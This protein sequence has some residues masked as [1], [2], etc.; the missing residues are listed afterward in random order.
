MPAVVTSA[1]N[2]S[3]K[4]LYKMARMRQPSGVTAVAALVI[5]VGLTGC[6]SGSHDQSAL[7]RKRM[8]ESRASLSRFA[9]AFQHNFVSLYVSIDGTG[10]FVDCYGSAGE[11]SYQVKL[12]MEDAFK[13]KSFRRDLIGRI[14]AYLKNSEWGMDEVWGPGTLH[15]GDAWEISA[16]K[17]KDKFF[18]K[19]AEKASV[20][21]I[22]ISGPC[23]K[24]PSRSGDLLGRV[25]KFHGPRISSSPAVGDSK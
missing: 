18:L 3:S 7:P 10:D 23:L 20:A 13:P 9:S 12:S 4:F 2:T 19:N 6:S 25:D 15:D 5:S 11:R 16:L 14:I 21:N 22:E 1:L 17:D 8:E 24:P